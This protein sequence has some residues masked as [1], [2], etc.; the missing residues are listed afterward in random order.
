MFIIAEWET[1][2]KKGRL[3]HMDVRQAAA[4]VIVEHPRAVGRH[5]D[6]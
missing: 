3:L 5:Q 1:Q 6:G 4:A 2:I